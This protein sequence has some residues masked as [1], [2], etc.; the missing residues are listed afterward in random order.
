MSVSQKRYLD[1]IDGT[2]RKRLFHSIISDYDLQTGVCELVDNAID[3]W[4]AMKKSSALRIAITLDVDRQIITVKDN[5]GGVAQKDAP[6][7][8]SPGA[9]REHPTD[10]QVGTFGVGGKRAGVALGE[11]VEI[12]SRYKREK[13]IQIDFTNDWLTSDDWNKELFEIPNI[14]PRTTIVEIS[15]IRQGFT[16]A[17][18]E[19]MRQH[20]AETYAFFIID[21][22]TIA[23][24]GTD[25]EPIVFDVWA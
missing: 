15:K 10:G 2:P 21:G 6:L 20:L 18:V 3:Q 9:T 8:V 17:N 13:S 16:K 1:T 24:N 22:C 5:A 19:E 4:I 25:I 12:R 11:H 14:E 23:L 7:L